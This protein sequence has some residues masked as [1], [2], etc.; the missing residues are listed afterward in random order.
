MQIKFKGTPGT[1]SFGIKGNGL[2]GTNISTFAVLESADG[3]NWTPVATYA[4]G[5][6]LTTSRK[7]ERFTLAEDS[8]FMQFL[9]QEKGSGNVGIY[10]VYIGEAGAADSSVTVTG[11][12]A[13]TFGGTFEL[14]LT[15]KNYTGEYA[16]AWEA[17]IIGYVNPDTATF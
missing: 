13:L 8:R 3:E 6:N 1:L 14:A 7:D 2:S 12:T 16:W 4:T 15:L 10:D 11:D 17:A 9:Y 5:D